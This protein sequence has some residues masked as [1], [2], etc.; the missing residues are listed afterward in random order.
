MS[1]FLALLFWPSYLISLSLN[2]ICRKMKIIPTFIR[3]QM[4]T[5]IIITTLLWQAQF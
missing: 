3:L 1:Q 4:I 2:Y 5:M